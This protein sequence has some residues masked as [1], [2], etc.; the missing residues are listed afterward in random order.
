MPPCTVRVRNATSPVPVKKVTVTFRFADGTSRVK[1]TGNIHVKRGQ[2]V[3]LSTNPGDALKCV[4][5][6]RTVVTVGSSQIPKTDGVAPALCQKQLGWRVD[7][8][9]VS[10]GFAP[11]KEAPEAE[12]PELEGFVRLNPDPDENEEVAPD[13]TD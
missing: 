2:R 4:K 7:A 6:T 10:Q 8:T 13:A 11:E 5:Q 12:W 1:S 9:G 3:S